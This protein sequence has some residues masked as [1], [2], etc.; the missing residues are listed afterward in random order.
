MTEKGLAVG[1]IRH[2]LVIGA[3]ALFAAMILL[4]GGI[5]GA[6]LFVLAPVLVCVGLTMAMGRGDPDG[7]HLL[8]IAQRAVRPAQE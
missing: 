5:P 8:E 2:C 7:R 4:F 6:L 1:R 3:A